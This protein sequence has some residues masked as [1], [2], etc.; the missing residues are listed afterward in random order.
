M[1]K[2][3]ALTLH[4]PAPLAHAASG[5]AGDD[6][7]KSP[8]ALEHALKLSEKL[9]RSPFV[10]AAFKDK[11]DN[12]LMAMLL[13]Q[14]MGEKLF[15]VLNSVHFVGG[16]PGWS[17]AFLIARANASGVFSDELA[18]E[19]TGSGASLA[20][21]CSATLAKSGRRVSKTVTLEM[22]KEAGWTR[23]KI[24]D[25]LPEQMISYRAACFLIRLYCSGI[26]YGLR[27]TDELEDIA[28]S[29]AA[30]V[31]A[32]YTD[33]D[34]SEPPAPRPRPPSAETAPPQT[35]ARAQGERG[36]PPS[37]AAP[38]GA[39]TDAHS[40]GGAGSSPAV[41]AP[42]SPS[43]PSAVGDPQSP[44]GTSSA[45]TGQDGPGDADA[46][47]AAVLAEVAEL[48]ELCPDLLR[49][50][51]QALGLRSPAKAPTLQLEL[52]ISNVRQRL[53]E[54]QQGALLGTAVREALLEQIASVTAALDDRLGPE[55][56]LA[57]AAEF[58]MALAGDMVPALTEDE[59]R[60]R[61]YLQHLSAA[62]DGLAG[63]EQ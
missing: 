63:G 8:A 15:T 52:L 39:D 55:G 50:T 62:V 21:T 48:R 40:D 60:L 18:F 37:M 11:P 42:P 59:R 43:S 45:P 2:P 19:T 9:A 10:P 53:A 38:A 57:T 36:D 29:R 46:H 26:L 30:P 51:A 25:A 54:A 24:Y 27:P 4:E 20:V 5:G 61:A 49:E 41:P 32:E 17:S 22:A 13:A 35:R 56:V 7:L 23:N 3:T 1:T 28:A 6:I 12:V 58:G 47:R 44:S 34:P 31:E 33:P 14:D 16:K